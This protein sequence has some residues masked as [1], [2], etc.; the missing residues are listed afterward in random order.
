MA[1]LLTT[2]K[3]CGRL[4]PWKAKPCYCQKTHMRT[5]E[6][7]V[8]TFYEHMTEGHPFPVKGCAGCEGDSVRR[9]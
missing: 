8:R 7:D 6:K 4:D 3:A 1:K 9:A 5:K 2:C